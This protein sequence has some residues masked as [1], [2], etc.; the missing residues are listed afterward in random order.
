VL[1]DERFLQ[2]VERHNRVREQSETQDSKSDKQATGSLLRMWPFGLFVLLC[3]SI[4]YNLSYLLRLTG[5]NTAV[6]FG[7]GTG[8][9]SLVAVLAGL[10]GRSFI[11]GIGGASLIAAAV[12][13]TTSFGDYFFYLQTYPDGYSRLMLVQTIKQATH[14][15]NIPLLVLAL[16]APMA[17]V[18]WKTRHYLSQVAAKPKPPVGVETLLLWTT[19]VACLLYYCR[20]PMEIHS[21]GAATLAIYLPGLIVISAASSVFVTLPSVRWPFL[22]KRRWWHWPATAATVIGGVLLLCILFN[23]V[24]SPWTKSAIRSIEELAV[25]C[26]TASSLYLLGLWTLRASGFRW[27]SNTPMNEAYL[28]QLAS[29]D[30]WIGRRWTAGFIGVAMLTTFAV[31][32]NQRFDADSQAKLTELSRRIA[33]RGEAIMGSEQRIVGAALKSLTEKS[34]PLE[35]LES[36]DLSSLY[37]TDS[38]ITDDDLALLKRWPRLW[39]VDLAGTDIGDEALKHLAGLKLSSLNLSRTKVTAQGVA[40][41]LEEAPSISL[42]T[43]RGLQLTDDQLQLIYRPNISSWDLANNQLTDA[44][45]KK[46]WENSGVQSLNLSANPITLATFDST[47]RVGSLHLTADDCPLDDA[48]V[49][50]LV[51]AGVVGGMT[52]GKTNLTPFGLSGLLNAGI[53]IDLR[54]GSFTEAELASINPTCKFLSIVACDITGDFLTH[55]TRRPDYLLMYNCKVTDKQVIAWSK[56]NWQPLG[57]ALQKMDLTDRSIPAFRILDPKDELTI[58]GSKIT[59]AGLQELRSTELR[60]VVSSTDY[61]PEEIRI[62]KRAFPKLVLQFPFFP[63]E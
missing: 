19:I 17:M 53:R 43:L 9:L 32:L 1:V 55:W 38:S 44:G 54:S 56:L 34:V 3:L 61:T 16:A 7:L 52:L 63:R 4:A 5:F 59:A 62:L 27:A 58:M 11:R 25:A 31:A 2:P 57:L 41:L 39:S 35:I 28:V 24:L 40:R 36:S 10:C 50:K 51:A 33:D 23:L 20:V 48:T 30:R 42:L 12:F 18:R 46:L 15:F 47:T 22:Q 45:V 13:V 60:L 8:G 29:E 6:L 26:V 14:A 21:I 37:L 49:G